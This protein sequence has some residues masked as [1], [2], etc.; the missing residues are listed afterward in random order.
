MV[1]RKSEA[2][3]STIDILNESSIRQAL[4]D[5]PCYRCKALIK[6]G[7]YFSRSNSKDGST[8]GFK[9]TFCS[10]CI[11]IFFSIDDKLAAH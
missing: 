10:S 11:P 3:D 9:H 7:D 1:E 4:V 6:P 8:P 2:A 5:I